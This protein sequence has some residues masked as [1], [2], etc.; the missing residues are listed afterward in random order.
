MEVVAHYL[1]QFFPTREND[2]FWG[3]GFTEWHNVAA[4]RPL[5][6]SHVQPML[7]GE[8]G[9]YDLRV[10]DTRQQQWALAS[11]AGI[12]A[13]CHWYYWF[14]GGVRTL[15]PI[16]DGLGQGEFPEQKYCLGWANE[17]WTG[18]WHGAPDRVLIR[19]GYDQPDSDH[20][21]YLV[22][23][24][25]NPNYLHVESRPLL[26]LY[27]PSDIPDLGGWIAGLRQS[28]GRSGVADPYIIGEA[29]GPWFY[30]ESDVDAYAWN[31][32]PPP[33]GDSL[34]EEFGANA[35]RHDPAVYLFGDDYFNW[36][37][38]G[39]PDSVVRQHSTVVCG[40][41]NTPRC[42]RSGVVLQG[43]SGPALE[44]FVAEAVRLEAGRPSPHVVLVKSWNEWAEGSTLEPTW[45][46]QRELL[47]AFRAGLRA[48]G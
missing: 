17:S 43:V 41:D 14:G 25:R 45:R 2:S 34:F 32:P 31:P 38:R 47:T 7:P 20:H 16:V 6:E 15:A 11:E 3:P 29:A 21:D 42:G 28:C 18:V 33:P 39:R 44:R 13:F 24:F 27:R 46:S 4:A 26:Y 22:A 48:G 8:L 9:F 12:S 23:H 36:I 30:E 1:P 10:P 5:F 19:Q 35:L 40:F 37:H